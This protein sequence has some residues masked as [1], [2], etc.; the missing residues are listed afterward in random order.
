MDKREELKS[1]IIEKYKTITNFAKAAGISRQH[2]SNI[3]NGK[4]VGRVDIWEK[5]NRCLELT[6]AEL[7]QYQLELRILIKN[8]K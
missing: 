2:V 8:G 7:W 6:P 3:I 1:K 5:I 4:V